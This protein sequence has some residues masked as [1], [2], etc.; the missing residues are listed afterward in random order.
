MVFKR[1]YLQFPLIT[2]IGL[3]IAT[4]KFNNGHHYH[5]G[6]EETVNLS[7]ILEAPG[8]GWAVPLSVTTGVV[9]S[10]AFVG[11]GVAIREYL[12]RQ[13][14]LELPQPRRLIGGPETAIIL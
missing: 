10:L 4:G 2:L 11:A 8:N 5:A 3:I 13:Q 9:G 1:V 14:V 7:K 12:W 6:N